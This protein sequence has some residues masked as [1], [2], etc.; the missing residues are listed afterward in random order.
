MGRQVTTGQSM[1]P[2]KAEEIAALQ[3]HIK[4]EQKRIALLMRL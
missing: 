1:S 3:Q 4:D 2:K